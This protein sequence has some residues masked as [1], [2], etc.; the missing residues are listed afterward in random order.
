MN[1]FYLNCHFKLWK[2]N[3]TLLKRIVFLTAV[4][5]VSLVIKVLIPFYQFVSR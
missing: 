4:I 2:N 1:D 5:S 3:N